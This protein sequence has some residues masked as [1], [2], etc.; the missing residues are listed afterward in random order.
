MQQ[1]KPQDL[2]RPAT[3]G[4]N[5]IILKATGDAAKAKVY[6][7]KTTKGAFLPEEKKLFAQARGGS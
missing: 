7:D 6:L 3:A 2:D 4:Y 1:L 5:G